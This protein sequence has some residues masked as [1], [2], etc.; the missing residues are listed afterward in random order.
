MISS[1]PPNISPGLSF[2]ITP[3]KAAAPTNSSVLSPTAC[4]AFMAFSPSPRRKKI[5]AATTYKSPASAFAFMAVVAILRAAP[6]WRW[7]KENDCFTASNS[8]MPMPFCS[9]A[10]NRLSIVGSGP[11]T[12]AILLSSIFWLVRN[13][14]STPIAANICVSPSCSFL[15][16]PRYCL[17][18]SCASATA[19]QSVVSQNRTPAASRMLRRGFIL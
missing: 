17:C 6:Y 13:S 1:S 4:S 5:P 7:A 19:G 16:A 9:N 8:A 11:A 18:Q 15:S 12:A 14:L 10:C 2:S 3:F